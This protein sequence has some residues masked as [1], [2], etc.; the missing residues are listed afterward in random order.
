M[1]NGKKRKGAEAIRSVNMQQL[2][3]SFVESVL[4]VRR[5]DKPD[6]KTAAPGESLE[7]L[8]Q[9][10]GWQSGDRKHPRVAVKGSEAEEGTAP[11]DELYRAAR[12]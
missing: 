10:R 9:I 7:F 4:D 1:W 8:A 5:R 6:G 2:V 11:S 12:R 3:K